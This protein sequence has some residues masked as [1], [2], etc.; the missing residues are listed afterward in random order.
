MVFL[1][2]MGGRW[3]E[4]QLPLIARHILDLVAHSKTTA[5][6]IDAVYSRKCV[7]FILRH[8]C[9][10]LLGE[11]AQLT[12]VS[13]LTM[14]V[15][16]TLELIKGTSSSA[17]SAKRDD[18]LIDSGG[19]KEKEKASLQQHVLICAVIEIGSLIY[20]L[21]TAALP[22]VVG[23]Q[24]GVVSIKELVDKPPPLLS[25]LSGVL[26]VPYPAGRAAAGWC[27]R[28]LGLALP[29][30]L[31]LLTNY[32]LTQVSLCSVCVSWSILMY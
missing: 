1:S 23:D 16:Q 8:M 18:K 11:A 5:T 26:C 6:H 2:S 10:R 7:G 19:D 15:S 32:S 12:A 4:R 30:Q 14:L 28:C 3:V 13:H 27:M 22:L 31:S 24:V 29:S 25:A 21:N 17:P 20:N 9:G